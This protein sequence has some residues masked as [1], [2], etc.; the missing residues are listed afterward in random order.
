MFS[1]ICFTTI[2][3]ATYTFFFPFCFTKI[4]AVT[5]AFFSHFPFHDNLWGQ[6]VRFSPCSISRQCL[7]PLI[8]YFSPFCFTTISK[9][10]HTFSSI[11]SQQSPWPRFS[12]H[13]ASR[14]S[15]L[16]FD[17]STILSTAT[18]LSR[19]VDHLLLCSDG[20]APLARW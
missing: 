18:L 14:Q 10:T 2:S 11:C 20:H 17:Q 9:D 13:S 19:G 6:L 5:C 4:S 3:G 1:L 15:H 7:W 8:P 16:G 12:P